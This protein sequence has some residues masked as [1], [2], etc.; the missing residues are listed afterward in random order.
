MLAKKFEAAWLEYE[1]FG[2]FGFVV[3]SRD[4]TEPPNRLAPAAS[5]FVFLR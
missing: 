4:G 1:D 2:K 5:D 3:T